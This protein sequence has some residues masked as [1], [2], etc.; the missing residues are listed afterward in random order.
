MFQK[1]HF[2]EMKWNE[3]RVCFPDPVVCYLDCLQ[4]CNM[5]VMDGWQ[6]RLIIHTYIHTYIYI[7][8]YIHI[9]I[10][11]YMRLIVFT[12]A[13]EFK[14]TLFTLSLDPET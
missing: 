7:Y 8:I 4:D 12:A 14:F 3:V 10:Y 5:P 2:V 6:V 9:Y 11:I 1:F 13:Y